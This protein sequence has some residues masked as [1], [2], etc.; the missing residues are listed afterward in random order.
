MVFVVNLFLPICLNSAVWEGIGT[1]D[2]YRNLGK[3]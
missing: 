3:G 1:Q 2:D